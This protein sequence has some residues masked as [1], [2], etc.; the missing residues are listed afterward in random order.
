MTRTGSCLCGQIAFSTTHDLGS[1]T[2]CHCTQCRKSTGHFAAAT[3][4]L[5]DSITLNGKVTWYASSVTGR[6]GFC[7]ACGSYLFWEEGDGLANIMAGSLDDE[8]GLRMDG[9]IFY[10]DRGD[11][12]R[13]SDGLPCFAAGR[14]GPEVAP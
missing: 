14:S 8:T 10:A 6:R 11:Y 7:G 9:H 3:P 12:Y 1:V 13:A 2:A 5:W 4:A